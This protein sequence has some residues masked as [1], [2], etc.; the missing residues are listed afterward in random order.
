MAFWSSRAKTNSILADIFDVLSQINANLVAIGSHKQSKK[1][2]PYP[3]PGDREKKEKKIGKNA[4]P[5]AELDSW[6]EKKRKAYKDRNS[7]VK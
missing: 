5:A 6:L 7:E 2:K 3:R 1:P 4:L